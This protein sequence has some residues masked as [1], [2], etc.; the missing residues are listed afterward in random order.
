MDADEFRKYGHELID[1]AADYLTHM[2]NR[3]VKPHTAPGEVRAALPASPPEDPE[4]FEQIV[5]DF[6]QI[7][8]PNVVHWNHPSFFAYFPANNSF[9]SILG[10]LLS[11][12]LG[13]NG[14]NWAT[15]PAATELEETVM[16]WVRQ[17]A[18]LPDHFKGCIQ[19]TASTSTLIALLCARERATGGGA[20]LRGLT[21]EG[22]VI[23]AY[24]SA[25][26]HSSV[27]K[28]AKIAGYG[29]EHLRL[30]S[31][32]DQ[33]A[34][35]PEELERAVAADLDRGFKPACVTATI[36]TTSST[37]VDPVRRIGDICRRYGLWLHVDG[38]LAGSA[39]FLPEMRHLNDGL[40]LADSYVF[41]AHKWLFTNFD[42]SLYYVADVEALTRTFEIMPEYLKTAQDRQATNF[43][44]WSIAL[45]RR[46]RALKLWFVIRS[47]GLAGLR[48]KLRDHINWAEQFAG[49][50]KEDPRFEL[51][52]PL[53]VQTVCFRYHP[54]GVDDM[55]ELN[56]LNTDLAE[57]INGDGRVYLTPTK[58]KGAT[59]L[60]LSIGQTHTTLA[61]VEK[62]WAVIVEKAGGLT[63]NSFA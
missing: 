57:A 28:A 22:P 19:D 26:A 20:N 50:V 33:L 12:A 59:T 1:W 5:S 61:H 21:A 29:K 25:E 35:R 10:E 63:E 49:W 42:C 27:E 6:K 62:A 55:E 24:A 53:T 34:M 3:P 60:R 32:D 47:F 38:A 7:V 39:A 52:A 2:E 37:A 11:A 58:L 41:N 48:E 30:V 36:G 31:T 15:S 51:T 8:V 44:D 18:G 16:D 23:T 17:A 4:P 43:R 40:E 13:V 46:F 56:R 14:M 54:Q 9:P 45:G